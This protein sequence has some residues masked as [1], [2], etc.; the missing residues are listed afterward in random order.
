MDGIRNLLESVIQE[1]GNKWK[2]VEKELKTLKENNLNLVE[3]V[4]TLT[5]A[6]KKARQRAKKDRENY[7]IKETEWRRYTEKLLNRQK[8]IPNCEMGVLVDLLQSDKILDPE[9]SDSTNN[10]KRKH[11]PISEDELNAVDESTEKQIQD[12]DATITENDTHKP[13]KLKKFN[14]KRQRYRHHL[15]GTTNCNLPVVDSHH[16]DFKIDITES[17]PIIDSQASIDLTMTQP[18]SPVYKPREGRLVACCPDMIEDEI[19]EKEEEIADNDITLS[20]IHDANNNYIDQNETKSFNDLNKGLR[21]TNENYENELHCVTDEAEGLQKSS[22]NLSDIDS[23]LEELGNTITVKNNGDA[24]ELISLTKRNSPKTPES[25][26]DTE[27]KIKLPITT[28][29]QSFKNHGKKPNFKYSETVRKKNERRQLDGH[30]CDLCKKYYSGLGLSEKELRERMK[31]CSRHRAVCSRPDTP[32]DF[33]STDFPDTQ[34]LIEKRMLLRAAN[35]KVNI[36]DGKT[37]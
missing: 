4:Q 30:A 28:I 11:G 23:N 2:D 22:D 31:N 26:R 20:G 32:P 37:V 33:W 16:N 21:N 7:L 36:S 14:K 13:M 5:E 19:K 18:S 12:D 9:L 24:I 25:I 1:I 27:M 8:S 29:D 34:T 17:V 10:K 3:Q 15:T 6:L 35:N